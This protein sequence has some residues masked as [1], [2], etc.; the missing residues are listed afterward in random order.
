[1]KSISD[2]IIHL[3]AGL[4]ISAPLY[5]QLGYKQLV[6]VET[7]AELVKQLIKKFAHQHNVHIKNSAISAQDEYVE[8]NNYS[9]PRYGS[10]LP[11]EPEFLKNTNLHLQETK[12]VPAITFAQLLDELK[13]TNTQCNTLII[14]LNGNEAQFL[15]SLSLTE[16]TTFSK[17][18]VTLQATTRYVNQTNAAAL[19]TALTAKGFRLTTAE[20]NQC[21]YEKDEQLSI[22][23]QKHARQ[24]AHI[25][26][27]QYERDALIQENSTLHQKN[28]DK[29]E[30]HQQELAKTAEDLLRVTKE[31]D[32]Q[33]LWNQKHKDWAESLK[34]DIETLKKEYAEGERAQSLALKLQAKAQVDL[35]NLR[36]QYQQKLKQEKNLIELIR[37]LQLKLQA[38][39]NYYHQLQLQHPELSAELIESNINNT[40]DA[41]VINKPIGSKHADKQDRS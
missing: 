15:T 24:L 12:Q 29:A 7:S 26:N 37:E 39:A 22:I 21:I 6:L 3:G 34:R 41:E 18:I 20:A 40:I 1:M 2:I 17:I 38:A 4:G 25:E 13:L 35:D 8:F 28:K 5:Q 19:S 10:Q 31:R 36:T 16:I 9:N 32:D 27:L 30:A 23:L 14:E 11:L 33:A